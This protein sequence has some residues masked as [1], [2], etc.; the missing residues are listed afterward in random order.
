VYQDDGVYMDG[1]RYAS[2]AE[3]AEQ[4]TA[5]ADTGRDAEVTKDE[6]WLPLGVFA[7]VVGDE[8]TSNH[9]FQLAVNKKGIIR[10]NYYDAV[11]DTTQTVAGS[12]DKKTQRAAWTIGDSKTPIYE[13]GI[14]NMTKGVMTM[15]VH[16]GKERSVQTTLVRIEDPEKPSE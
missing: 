10:G 13:T 12:V 7:M 3:Y 1:E 11:K 5:I 15:M 8:T 4:A 9:I 16:Y 6:M 14:S 2:S